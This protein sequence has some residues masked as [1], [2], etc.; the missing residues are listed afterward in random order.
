[1]RRSCERH[2]PCTSQNGLI[3]AGRCTRV[4][5]KGSHGTRYLVTRVA[6]EQLVAQ[7]A[8]AYDSK[9]DRSWLLVCLVALYHCRVRFP[10]A[11]QGNGFRFQLANRG[12]AR[13]R[14]RC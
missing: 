2:L 14:S 11:G 7:R 13:E 8:K 12:C 3:L 10:C 6:F 1:M 4:P 9:R 5:F